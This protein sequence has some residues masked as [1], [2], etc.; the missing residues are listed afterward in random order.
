MRLGHTHPMWHRFRL[1]GVRAARQGPGG[2]W[3]ILKW[4]ERNGLPSTRFTRWR[5]KWR[6]L[7]GEGSA[8]SRTSAL[9]S[10]T[11]TSWNYRRLWILHVCHILW[12]LMVMWQAGFLMENGKHWHRFF[13]EPETTGSLGGFGGSNI[14]GI[15]LVGKFSRII[16]PI[17]I[18]FFLFFS[19][20]Y[21][22]AWW[23]LFE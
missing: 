10:Y 11:D 21:A 2:V 1:G 3:L 16:D 12:S 15:L 4:K 9:R 14:F 23:L 17:A 20:M 6:L 18:F 7:W 19:W 22:M 13:S 5:V 8:G